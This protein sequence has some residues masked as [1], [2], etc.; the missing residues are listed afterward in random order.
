[1]YEVSLVDIMIHKQKGFIVGCGGHGHT[2]TAGFATPAAN[3]WVKRLGLVMS[4]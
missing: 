1:M 3:I 4:Q 2:R